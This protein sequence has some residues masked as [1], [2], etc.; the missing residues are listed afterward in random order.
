MPEDELMILL[1]CAEDSCLMGRVDDFKW[2]AERPGK[3][4]IVD[5]LSKYEKQGWVTLHEV[6]DPADDRMIMRARLTSAGQHRIAELNRAGVQPSQAVDAD[7]D[8]C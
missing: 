7:D 2:Q 3:S 1:E 6:L 8:V 4:P 5:L